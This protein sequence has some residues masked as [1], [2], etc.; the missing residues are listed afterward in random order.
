M[1]IYWE[2]WKDNDQFV[3]EDLPYSAFVLYFSFS[4][5]QQIPWNWKKFRGLCLSKLYTPLN[6]N[7]WLC[8]LLASLMV[9]V[10]LGA[11]A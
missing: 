8:M 3:D 9:L 7:I 5:I 11:N 10:T 1:D 2:Q 6:I 4:N